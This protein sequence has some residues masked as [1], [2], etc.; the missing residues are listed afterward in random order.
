M[1]TIEVYN[2]T[3]RKYKVV[4]KARTRESAL[5][6]LSLVKGRA[7]AKGADGRI[8]AHRYDEDGLKGRLELVK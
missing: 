8:F 7:R 2:K 5:L 1:F 4:R 3:S 6:N